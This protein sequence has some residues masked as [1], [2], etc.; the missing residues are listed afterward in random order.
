VEVFTAGCV[1]C[2]EAVALVKRI[3]CPSCEVTIR[4]MK[5]ERSIRRAKELGIKR[6]P[7]VAIHGKIAD[8]CVDGLDEQTLRAAGIGTAL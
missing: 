1:C 8:C 5:Q 3:A 2:D 7:T 6:V 4:D